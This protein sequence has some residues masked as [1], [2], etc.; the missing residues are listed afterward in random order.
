MIRPNDAARP[1]SGENKQQ[2]PGIYKNKSGLTIRAELAARAMQGI[3]STWG[4]HDVTDPEEVAQD[5]VAYAD[6]LI[7]QLNKIENT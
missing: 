3:I 2:F 6:A 7:S 1:L 5:A 4:E